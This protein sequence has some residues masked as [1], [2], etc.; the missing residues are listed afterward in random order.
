MNYY[1]LD[2]DFR[3]VEGVEN[4]ISMIWNEKYYEVGDFEL[5][6]P[7]STRSMDIWTEAAKKGYIIVRA[8]EYFNQDAE[9]MHGMIVEKVQTDYAC[10]TQDNLIITGPSLKGLLGRR[11]IY[12]KYDASGKVETVIRD[13]V[14][15]NCIHPAD[16][17][18][19][20]PRLELG[21][22]SGVTDLV[23]TRFQGTS[24]DEAI[25]T[26]CKLNKTGWDIRVDMLRKKFV[27][28]VYKGTD[29]SYGQTGPLDKQNP[30]VVFSSE[31]EN[32]QKTTYIVDTSNFANMAYV[33]AEYVRVNEKSHLTEVV[34]A[35]QLVRSP[36]AD[37]KVSG[38][39]RYE[40]Y[41]DGS[42]ILS[43][44]TQDP[45]KNIGTYTGQLRYKGS[46]TL[47]D[48]IVKTEMTGEVENTN[49]FILDKDYYLGDLVSVQNAYGQRLEVRVTSTIM[50]ESSS[51]HSYIP[52]FTVENF[53]DKN[54]ED[55]KTIKEDEIRGLE[56]NYEDEYR[57]TEDGELRR[58]DPGYEYR[59]REIEDNGYEDV[60]DR[61]RSSSDNDVRSCVKDP[62]YNKYE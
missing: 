46:V 49:T 47:R 23:N 10:K 53:T 12:G 18:R 34:D 35:S 9:H 32:L 2:H 24:I 42:N 1:L 31:M 5:Y 40:T 21:E 48:L 37:R 11:I 52:A 17:A 8:D 33:G 13:L 14:D 44:T 50:S 38:L 25:T 29:R 55:D 26:L 45:E 7:A 16:A 4:Y 62:I 61:S 51:K 39:D 6:L 60:A 36:K 30:Y 15:K 3:I 22:L 58:R 20:I 59:D 19:V 41:V 27:L 28:S 56:N 43:V 57:V 54:E